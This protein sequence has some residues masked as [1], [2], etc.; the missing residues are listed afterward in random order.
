MTHKISAS[1]RS[2]LIRY[3]SRLPKGSPERRAILS[4]VMPV[5]LSKSPNW[6]DWVELEGSAYDKAER[7]LK[8]FDDDLFV[9]KDKIKGKTVFLRHHGMVTLYVAGSDGYFYSTKEMTPPDKRVVYKLV[10]VALA[11]DLDLH[12]KEGFYRNFKVSA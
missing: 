6:A 11:G 9:Y 3:A 4:A 5:L 10:E 12:P 7:L 2:T 8:S 1:D